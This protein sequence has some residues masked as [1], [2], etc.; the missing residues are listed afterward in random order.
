M[1]RDQ[2]VLAA[3]DADGRSWS[4]APPHRRERLIIFAL[5][6]PAINLFGHPLDG[7]RWF[8]VTGAVVLAALVCWRVSSRELGTHPVPWLSLAVILALGIALFAAGSE[9]AAAGL[10]GRW[11]RG[12]SDCTR[13]CR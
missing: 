8:Q 9:L 6:Q 5:L 3:E 4:H 11:S 12:S 10:P 7:R 2:S 1:N 13:Q